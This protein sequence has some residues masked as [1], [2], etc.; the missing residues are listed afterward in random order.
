MLR[1]QFGCLAFLMMGMLVFANSDREG[2]ILIPG[3]FHG[4][5]ITAT[6]G[7]TWLAL[8]HQDGKFSLEE[9]ILTV[10]AIHDQM[11]DKPGEKTGKKIMTDKSDQNVLL[12]VNA[13]GLRVGPVDGETYPGHFF[14]NAEPVHIQFGGKPYHLTMLVPAK[15]E[16]ETRSPLEFSSTNKKQTL[17]SYY[18]RVMND[19]MYVFGDE[20]SVGIQWIGDLDG[21]NKPDLIMSLSDHYNVMETVLLLSSEAK[22]G[23]LVKEV[24]VFRGVGC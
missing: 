6:S 11:V 13:P 17:R 20:G 8:I 23:E 9:T 15:V 2:A 18:T 7:E 21:D 4:D 24:A 10:E 1:W 3:S 14:K 5:E 16:R 22:E 12:L 19:S